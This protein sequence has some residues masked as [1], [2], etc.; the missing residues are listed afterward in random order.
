MKEPGRIGDSPLCG[1]GFYADS[2]IGSAAAT[3]LGED[4]TKGVLSYEVVRKIAEGMT[5]QEACDKTLYD[6][7]EDLIKRNDQIDDIQI[8][9]I[10]MNKSG[11]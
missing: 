9:L 11:N 8:S 6:F 1:C 3:G 4:I 7:E 10:A 5:P 2:N